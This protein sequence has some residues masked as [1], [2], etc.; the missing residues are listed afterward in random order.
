M[1]AA[2]LAGDAADPS[3]SLRARE[4]LSQVRHAVESLPDDQ[5]TV[6]VMKQ[7]QQLSFAEIAAILDCPVGTV[8]SRM[9]RALGRLRG[10]LARHGVSCEDV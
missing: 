4:I 5:R 3:D 1:S 9:H 10:D 7:Y 2:T 8:K 6:L